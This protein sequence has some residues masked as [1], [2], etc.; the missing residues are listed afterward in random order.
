M[1]PGARPG[2]QAAH[3]GLS[4]L[5]HSGRAVPGGAKQR[6]PLRARTA[7]QQGLGSPGRQAGRW[8]PGSWLDLGSRREPSGTPAWHPGIPALAARAHPDEGSPATPPQSKSPPGQVPPPRAP[9]RGARG[10][11]G[12]ELKAPG[13]H[14]SG[15]GRPRV[16]RPRTSR[17]QHGH[18]RSHRPRESL[19][20]GSE[21]CMPPAGAARRAPTPKVPGVRGSQ[22]QGRPLAG[23][24]G[25]RHPGP[26]GRARAERS[27]WPPRPMPCPCP[28]RKQLCNRKNKRARRPP[29][30]RVQRA[31]QS[32]VI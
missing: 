20:G 5:P 15:P 7:T 13:A 11:P 17:E 8:A 26:H 24:G 28:A 1:E 14:V 22:L 19:A 23:P 4:Y 21:K 32:A 31:A 30:T 2:H 10:A 3:L 6:A 12:G 25:G 9:R 16:S 27:P 18:A 29:P